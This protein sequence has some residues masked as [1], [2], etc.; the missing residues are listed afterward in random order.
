MTDF[1]E[2]NELLIPEWKSGPNG[3]EQFIFELTSAKTMGVLQPDKSLIYASLVKSQKVSLLS[4][5]N[6]TQLNNLDNF[7]TYLRDTFGPSLAEQRQSFSE[8]RQLKDENE[9]LYLERCKKHY[10]ASRQIQV[11]KHFTDWMKE[12]IKF[13]FISGINNAE[14]Q[15]IMMINAQN[16]KFEDL[17]TTARNYAVNLKDISKVYQIKSNRHT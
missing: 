5:L 17:G 2:V 11:G 8:I 6:N 1:S 12:D 4:N 15:R 10:A 3:L 9:I 16:V 14:L 7:V 13:Q